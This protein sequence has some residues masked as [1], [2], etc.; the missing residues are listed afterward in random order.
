AGAARGH[1]IQ[2][3]SALALLL[4]VV[5]TGA[6]YATGRVAG[7]F[8]GLVPMPA[9]PQPR[10]AQPRPGPERPSQARPGPAVRPAGLPALVPLVAILHATPAILYGT[11]RYS[12]A[13]KHVGVID[14]I[15]HH[16]IEFHLGGV[17]GAY[18]GWPGFFALNSFLT[19]ASG[20]GS[21]LSYASWALP[22]NDLL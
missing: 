10:P 4:A 9:P 5:V 11:L 1:L 22:V 15:S 19:S 6:G 13:W 21:A 7:P 17:L 12:W 16:G 2:L 14:F 20:Q 3:V 18:Q 8:A